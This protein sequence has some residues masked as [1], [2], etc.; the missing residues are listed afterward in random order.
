MFLAA[1]YYNVLLSRKYKFI[2]GS[3]ILTN[4]QDRLT[5]VCWIG[6]E[7]LTGVKQVSPARRR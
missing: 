6:G 3:K 4:G 2:T 1:K 5:D 7:T